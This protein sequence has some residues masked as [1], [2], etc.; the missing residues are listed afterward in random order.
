[1]GEADENPSGVGPVIKRYICIVVN[2]GVGF[3]NTGW[4]GECCASLVK[5]RL[6]MPGRAYA[7]CTITAYIGKLAGDIDKRD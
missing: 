7:L 4:E 5:M 1:M 2:G 6:N 3:D